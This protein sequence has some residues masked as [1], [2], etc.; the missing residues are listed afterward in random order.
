MIIYT[1]KNNSATY[2]RLPSLLDLTA[3]DHE[4]WSHYASQQ[5]CTLSYIPRNL[6][7]GSHYVWSTRVLQI[8]GSFRGFLSCS[9]VSSVPLASIFHLAIGCCYLHTPR[10]VPCVDTVVGALGSGVKLPG[11]L[12]QTGR[13][14]CKCICVTYRRTNWR[15]Q[16][17]C[18]SFNSVALSCMSS[19]NRSITMI[20][21][22]VCFTNACARVRSQHYNGF[23]P[24]RAI[25][26]SKS[27][28]HDIEWF[29]V[30]NIPNAR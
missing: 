17:V 4:F 6:A 19:L 21:A 18:H 8:S 13:H 22:Q 28:R 20:T 7:C 12:G 15:V 14:K 25:R 24:V 30:F 11:A 29:F 23:V 26:T 2:I 3:Y 10:N 1:G 27:L 16:D 9:L 5:L